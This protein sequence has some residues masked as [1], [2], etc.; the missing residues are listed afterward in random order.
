MSGTLKISLRAGERIY[1]NGAVFR[2]DRKVSLEL[3]NSVTFLL[4][5]HVMKPE[6]TTTPL[7]QLYFMVQTALIEPGGAPQAVEMANASLLL[8]KSAFSNEEVL[9]G[10][11]EVESLLARQRR[12]ECLKV[13]RGLIAIEAQ[14]LAGAK[15]APEPKAAIE[16]RALACR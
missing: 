4:E 1:I 15:G 6:D 5:Q 14:I 16:E 9:A 12:F 7:R 13:I 2:V 3:L 11:A 8:L 10:L